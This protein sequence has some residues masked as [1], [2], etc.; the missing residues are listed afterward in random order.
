MADRP[1]YDE[2]TAAAES[3]TTRRT[4]YRSGETLTEQTWSLNVRTNGEGGMVVWTADDES[5]LIGLVGGARYAVEEMQRDGD[6]PTASV[7]G[8]K[9]RKNGTVELTSHYVGRVEVPAASTRYL[10]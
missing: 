3:V 7:H 10:P 1:T 5:R 2:I 6:E 8:R 4:V 9:L